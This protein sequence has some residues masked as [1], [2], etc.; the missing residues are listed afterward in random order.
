MEMLGK[1]PAC[2]RYLERE[3]FDISSSAASIW[4]GLALHTPLLSF[5]ALYI[6]EESFWFHWKASLSSNQCG[7][8]T[9]LI[10]PWGY[11]QFSYQRH[12]VLSVFLGPS[13]VPVSVSPL[14]C[15]ASILLLLIE[16]HGLQAGFPSLCLAPLDLM[17]YSRVS[18]PTQ[19]LL[20]Y[21]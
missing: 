10:A 12:Q 15:A 19:N 14:E 16:N 21:A 11:E 20:S 2:G 8:F 6:G 7:A 18:V 5:W 17:L 1:Q 9:A 4:F 13:P 3:P